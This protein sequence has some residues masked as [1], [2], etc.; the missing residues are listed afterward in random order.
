MVIN[1]DFESRSLA[2]LRAVGAYKYAEH[3]STDILC[4][5]YQIDDGPVIGTTDRQLPDDLRAAL[6]QGA[7]LHAWNA[8]FEY[9]I[10][11]K[12][13]APK[14]GW[15]RLR[16]EQLVDTMARAAVQNLPQ[17]LGDCV[18]ALG[19]PPEFH[20]DKRGEHLIQLLSKPISAG[21]KKGQFREDATLLAEMV[22]YC[23]QDVVA[24][25][26]LGTI[27]KPMWPPE[28]AVWLGTLRI[29]DR[30]L[31]VALDEID[32]VIDVVDREVDHL[33]AELFQLTGI[34][35]ASQRNKVLEALQSSGL[36]IE[37]LTSEMLDKT[38]LRDDLTP[39]QRRVIEIRA[40]VAQTS[41]SK[42]P[43]MK[44]LACSDARI[45]G[46][47]TY[48]GASTGRDASRGLNAQNLARPPLKAVDHAVASMTAFDWGTC[49]AIWGDETMGAAVS[50]IRGVIKAPPG[51]MFIDADFSSVENRV[52]AWI[53]GQQDK[54]DMFAKGLDE[55]KVFASG[56]LYRVPYDEVTKDQR[57]VSKSAVLGSMF[58]QGWKGL[59]EFAEGYGVELSEE[60]SQAIVAA[61]RE[62]YSE[63]PK[64]WYACGDAM[65]QACRA[66]GAIVQ[67]G[68]LQFVVREKFLKLKL[69]SERV[70][71]WYDPKIEERETPWGAMRDAV[72]TWSVNSVTR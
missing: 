8:S 63:L 21:G 41:T 57:Q 69:P 28:Q 27:L 24:E 2:D 59:I 43:K 14:Y 29:N 61:Y 19:L 20:K 15:P 12:V 42:F 45:H 10:W 3:H 55:Y 1:F 40:A 18:K 25:H 7:E 49:R 35:A 62:E 56:S 30:G 37:D 44:A 60:R 58:G 68:K 6:D 72:V 13:C 4:Y 48:H 32:N 31:P 52:A 54:L 71:Y 16:P 66:P 34:T 11:N 67:V 39:W 26:K 47:L 64:T 33:N 65:L 22:E 5:A 17:A 36:V 50:T 51:R 46:L 38:L 70:L 53:A 23:R 9:V